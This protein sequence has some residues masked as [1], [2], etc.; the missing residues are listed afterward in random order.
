MEN[1]K[2]AQYIK[3]AK[4]SGLVVLG[5]LIVYLAYGVIGC[6][7]GW[8]WQPEFISGA[9]TTRSFGFVVVGCVYAGFLVLALIATYIYTYFFFLRARRKALKIQAQQE[10]EQINKA[11]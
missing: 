4:I 11:A 8:G 3:I 2:K 9:D 1:N 7:I 5:I 6:F 10:K